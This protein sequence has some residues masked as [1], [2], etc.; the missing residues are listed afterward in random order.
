LPDERGC[1]MP[2]LPAED[3][4]TAASNLSYHKHLAKTTENYWQEGISLVS[5]ILAPLWTGDSLACIL[6]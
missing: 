5:E 1:A 6:G 4:G 3:F 2:F